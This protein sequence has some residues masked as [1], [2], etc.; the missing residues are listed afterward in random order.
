MNRYEAIDEG[1]AVQTLENL[2]TQLDKE[3]DLGEIRSAIV[4]LII[5]HLE[6]RGSEL[7]EHEMAHFVNAVG[8]LTHAVDSNQAPK[9][10]NFRV[11]LMDLQKAISLAS[12][13]SSENNRRP[14]IPHLVTYDLLMMAALACKSPQ[15]DADSE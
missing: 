12:N 2:L 4:D 7:D 10:A 5:H 14:K 9:A 8:S 1:L 11:C 13:V 3:C 6:A 15:T